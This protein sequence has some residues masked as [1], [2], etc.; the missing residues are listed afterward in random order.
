M[1]RLP[2]VILLTVLMHINEAAVNTSNGFVLMINSTVHN[3]TLF[4]QPTREATYLGA[5]IAFVFIFFGLIGNI[6]LITTILS[7]KKLR[8]NIINIF[9]VSVSS[10]ACAGN[11]REVRSA[12]CPLPHPSGAFIVS[13]PTSLF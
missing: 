8:T 3:R 6:L 11:A 13:P 5:I 4:K 9:I 10:S 7:V 1:T 2:S 12:G